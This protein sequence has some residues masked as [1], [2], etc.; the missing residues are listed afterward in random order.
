MAACKYCG[1]TCPKGHRRPVAWMEKHE[2][3]CPN[4]PKNKEE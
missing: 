3:N 1:I 2:K 4:N